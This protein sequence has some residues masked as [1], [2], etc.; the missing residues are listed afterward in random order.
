MPDGCFNYKFSKDN[1]W[2][3]FDEFHLFAMRMEFLTDNTVKFISNEFKN[4]DEYDEQLKHFIENNQESFKNTCPEDLSTE[5]R[6]GVLVD[7]RLDNPVPFPRNLLS[8]SSRDKRSFLVEYENNVLSWALVWV[9][10]QYEFFLKRV[11]II[12]QNEHEIL[13]QDDISSILRNS[14]LGLNKIH[15]FLISNFGD[16]S[17]FEN[18]NSFTGNNYYWYIVFL[19]KIRHIIVHNQ[20]YINDIS[21]FRNSLIQSVGLKGNSAF[22]AF[23][24]KMIS[25]YTKPDEKTSSR[26]VVR[27]STRNI[28]QVCICPASKKVNNLMQ[29]LPNHALL[30]V[31]CIISHIE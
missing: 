15:K 31:N 24:G 10:E 7:L 5:L 9:Y 20:G 3:V 2:H 29:L 21:S 4:I 16:I 27:L 28:E 30:I 17:Q 25:F 12:C 11:Y 1:L 23:I 26:F 19:E 6:C 14:K 18:H 8:S 22:E 13:S